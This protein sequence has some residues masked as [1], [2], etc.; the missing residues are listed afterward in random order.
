MNW[1]RQFRFDILGILW[2]L[3]GYFLHA[4]PPKLI[5]KETW[6]FQAL[7]M[8]ECRWSLVYP[9]VE[10][11][12]GLENWHQNFP[13][14]FAHFLWF[15][16]MYTYFVKTFNA[17]VVSI[18]TGIHFILWERGRSFLKGVNMVLKSSYQYSVLRNNFLLFKE[19]KMFQT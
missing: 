5:V 3:T 13:Q 17:K 14:N 18:S 2:F 16:L 6:N 19:A 1:W 8:N 4:T 15:L 12:P 7:K 10:H 11:T 9:K